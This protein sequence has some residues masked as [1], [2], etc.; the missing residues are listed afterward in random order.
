MKLAEALIERADLQKRLS[1][2]K[3]RLLINA[4]VQEGE[5]PAEE[6]TA[7][8]RELDAVILQLERLIIRINMTNAN[9]VL[10]NG[11]T[12]SSLLV[13]RDCL[14]MKTETLRDFLS[15]ASATVMRGTK[16]EVVI[17]ST[18]SVSDLQ[19]TVDGLSK[20]LRE[21]DVQIQSLNWTTELP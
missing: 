6:P 14:R 9:T 11:E 20:E 21:L 7:L 19:K 10:E 5:T 8:I 13:Q 2:L 3:N 15:D 16:T 18:V 1:Q 17:R 12:L 4:K